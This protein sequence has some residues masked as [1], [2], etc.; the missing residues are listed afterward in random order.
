MNSYKVNELLNHHCKLQNIQ[1]E[2]LFKRSKVSLSCLDDWAD[3]S[4]DRGNACDLIT[5]IDNLPYL[6]NE[7]QA[8][9]LLKAAGYSPRFLAFSLAEKVEID[10]NCEQCSSARGLLVEVLRKKTRVKLD[11]IDPNAANRA[12]IDESQISGLTDFIFVDIV[13]LIRKHNIKRLRRK[14]LD[15]LNE[16]EKIQKLDKILAKSFTDGLSEAVIEGDRLGAIRHSL[17]NGHNV[18]ERDIDNK[19]KQNGSAI[20]RKDVRKA[21]ERVI[22]G[23]W[24]TRGQIPIRAFRIMNAF[25]GR[26]NQLVSLDEIAKYFTETKDPRKSAA[27]TISWM[28]EQFIKAVTEFEIVGEIYYRV[29]R[30]R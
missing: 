25:K 5:I 24:R 27:S 13:P 3:A 29:Q 15:I 21:F 30:R 11:D 1:L 17:Y 4:V 7:K 18:V 16:Y 28:N 12:K 10:P 20:S 19:E 8:N 6:L 22:E 9:Q 14:S 26:E 2:G 23:P